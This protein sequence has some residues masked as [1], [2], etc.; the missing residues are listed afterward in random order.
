MGLIDPI[1]Q[2]I[3]QGIEQLGK[4]LVQTSQ[5]LADFAETP[6][7]KTH[8]AKLDKKEGLASKES[9]IISEIGINIQKGVVRFAASAPKFFAASAVKVVEVNLSDLKLDEPFFPPKMECSRQTLKQEKAHAQES[10]DSLAITDFI[11]GAWSYRA[12]GDFWKDKSVKTFLWAGLVSGFE[13]GAPAI[14]TARGIWKGGMSM[15]G[16]WKLPKLPK[17]GQWV[18]DFNGVWKR[19]A[20]K[21]KP[22]KVSKEAKRAAKDWIQQC[23]QSY[24]ALLLDPSDYSKAQFLNCAISLLQQVSPRRLSGREIADILT[25]RSLSSELRAL[26]RFLVDHLEPSRNLRHFNQN[27]GRSF[28]VYGRREFAAKQNLI[29]QIDRLDFI[30]LNQNR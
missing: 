17:G 25:N 20:K 21:K 4:I 30:L 28:G 8:Q 19:R 12:W 11:P 26:R 9:S 7:S 5:D 3:N 2:K 6:A 10:E 22:L 15:I 27:L 18:D 23:R 24:K 1:G 16:R 29:Q 13:L 14:K